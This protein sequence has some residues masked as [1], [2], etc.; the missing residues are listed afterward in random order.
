MADENVDVREKDFSQSNPAVIAYAYETFRPEDEVLAAVRKEAERCG[1][2]HIAV[3][4]FDALHLELLVRMMGAKKA[5]EIGTLGGYSGVAI[6]RGLGA[7]GKLHTFE[8]DPFHAEVASRAFANSQLLAEV[9][10]HSGPAFEN[11]P[12]V[13]SEAPFDLV[14]IDADK[15]SYPRYLEWATDHLRVGGVVIADNTFAWG[16]IHESYD[17]PPDISAAVAGLRAFNETVVSSGR[18][19]ATILPTGEGLT[20]A[21]KLR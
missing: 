2:P 6:A 8:L 21:V 7:G 18:Y 4:S 14:F 9:I 3:G 15:T 20:V 10:V 16:R 1:L 19:R 17:L 5:I 13:V 12:S 11:L